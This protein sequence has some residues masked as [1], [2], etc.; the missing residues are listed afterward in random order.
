MASLRERIAYRL[1]GD[2]IERE[3]NA[4]VSVRVD[5]SSGW[6]LLAGGGPHDR[7]W[8]E[9]HEDLDDTLEAWYKNFLVRRITNLMTSY[10]VGGGITVTSEH[11]WVE[12]FVRK[13][14]EHEKNEIDRR[15]EP[16]CDELTR[17]GE[18][19][20]ILFTNRVDGTS[21]VRFL[22]ASQIRK[23]KCDSDDY[24]KELAYG[25]VQDAVAELKWWISPE[26][27]RAFEINEEDPPEDAN[28]GKKGGLPPVV[29][30]FAVNRPVG[31]TRGAGDL[32]PVLKHIKRYDG[33]LSDRVRLNRVRTRQAMLDVEI[34]D[35][36]Q[37]DKKRQQLR[38]DDP[39]AAG[40]YVH[41]PG[42]KTTLHTLNIRADEARDD[43]RAL[44]LAIATGAGLGLHYLGEGESINYAT[45]KEMGEP[46]SRFL[47]GRQRQ[48][49]QFLVQLVAVAYR[50]QVALGLARMPAGGDL[51]LS[52]VAPE[53]ARADNLALAQAA[54]E[55][56]SALA[57]MKVNGWIDDSTAIRLAFKFA[58]EVVGEDEID[59]ILEGPSAQPE[60]DE[61]ES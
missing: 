14:W 26:D 50:R 60:V 51:K 49:G 48:F 2:I 56:V 61:L 18:L 27:A 25:E 12:K 47:S 28:L 21:Y 30:H 31:A 43:G 53:V 57:E 3:V 37:V 6:D 59:E 45:A 17:A 36:S 19:F 33:W 32:G 41:G 29:L 52:A 7:L 38:R 35:D 39:L 44:R 16:M 5:D 34:A 20:P 58:G 46:T 10:V 8:S 24:E 13:F 15:L 22:V 9:L 55:I 54:R 42:E 4:A 23:I 40:T 11:P 1:F